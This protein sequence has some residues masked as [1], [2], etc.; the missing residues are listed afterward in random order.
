M[1]KRILVPLDGSETAEAVLP[2]ALELAKLTEGEIFLLSVPTDPAA[3]FAFGDPG[4]ASEFV[5]TKESVTQKYLK[6]IKK[7]LEDKGS[8][9]SMLIRDG[10]VA[11]V[12]IAVSEEINADIIAM[13]TH[14]RTG[15]AHLFLGSVAEKILRASKLPIMLIRPAV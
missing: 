4:L 10:A 14:A 8:K 6:S 9:V 7:D 2:H 13:S 3:A 11:P 1:Y 15:V 5:D 12:I